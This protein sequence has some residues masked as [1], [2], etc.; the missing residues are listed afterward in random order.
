MSESQTSKVEWYAM[1][2]TYQREVKVKAVLDEM[3]VECSCP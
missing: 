1:R 3:G 2:V